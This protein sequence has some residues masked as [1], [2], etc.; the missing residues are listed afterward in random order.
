MFGWCVAPEQ[1]TTSRNFSKLYFSMRNID[2][3]SATKKVLYI[4]LNL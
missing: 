4:I 1:S 3:C 2:L